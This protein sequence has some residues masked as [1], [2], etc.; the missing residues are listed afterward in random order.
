MK[1]K[2]TLGR[3]VHEANNFKRPCWLAL[4]VSLGMML[5]GYGGFFTM[6]PYGQDET[7]HPWRKLTENGLLL[8]LLTGILGFVVSLIWWFVAAIKLRCRGLFHRSPAALSASTALGIFTA[9]CLCGGSLHAQDDNGGG[10]GGPPPGQ[11]GDGGPGGPGDFGGPDGP[12][13]PPPGD[14][15]GGG[16][17]G[18]GGSGGN[19]DPAQFQKRMMDQM[20]QNLGVTND[21]E[22]AAIQPLIQKIMDARREA[23]GFGGMGMPGPGGPGGPG[24]PNARPGAPGERGRLGP[25]PSIEQQA[26]QKAIDENA[27]AQ[28]IKDALARYVAS[29]KEKQARLEAAQNNLRN[30]LSVKQEA[31]AV[32]LGLM[33]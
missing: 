8:L 32:L 29:R 22:W 27:S 23:G 14:I 2:L 20:R 1:T 3:F 24:G 5:T 17:G 15:G 31:Q 19:F 4:I 11:P 7:G 13:G 12:G 18:P 25:Q 28:Q 21:D 10:P 6:S 16:P 26:L 33:P 9:L 30:V